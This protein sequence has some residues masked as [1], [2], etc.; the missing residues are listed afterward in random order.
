M[1]ED[2]SPSPPSL[3]L[4]PSLSLSLRRASPVYS[5]SVTRSGCQDL[6]TGA[7]AADCRRRNSSAPRRS[8]LRCQSIFRGRWGSHPSYH[9]RSPRPSPPLRSPSRLCTLFPACPAGGR[10]RG[11]FARRPDLATTNGRWDVSATVVRR[12]WPPLCDL[13]LPVASP[14]VV[15]LPDLQAAHTLA[16]ACRGGLPG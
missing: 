12:R 13:T 11:I 8:W 2:L 1:I 15:P 10:R 7:P 5:D 3:P 6:K 9:S 16:R 4:P 14:P